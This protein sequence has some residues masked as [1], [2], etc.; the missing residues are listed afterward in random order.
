MPGAILLWTFFSPEKRAHRLP[1]KV[2]GLVGPFTPTW[3]FGLPNARGSWTCGGLFHGLLLQDDLLPPFCRRTAWFP[4]GVVLDTFNYKFR[5]WWEQ[6]LRFAS[7]V[8]R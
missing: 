6:P 4:F 5:S 2:A 3:C 1:G 8:N 7:A